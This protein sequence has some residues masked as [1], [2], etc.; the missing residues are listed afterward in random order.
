MIN[1]NPQRAEQ[2][3]ISSTINLYASIEGFV[4]K[5]NVSNGTYVSPSDVILEIVDT[6]HIH[7]ELSVFEKDIMK[8][9]KDQKILFKIP[10]ASETVYEAD[11][12]LVGTTI[13][14]QSRRVKVHGHLDN[15]EEN[16]IVGMFVVADIIIDT[17]TSMGLPIEAL[18]EGDDKAYV[19]VLDEKR[20]NEYYLKSI[21]LNLGKQT[22]SNIEILNHDILKDKQ[23]IIKGTSMLIN[24]SEGGHSH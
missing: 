7:L 22:E 8:I 6:D 12:H 3:Q 21:K 24:N 9:K 16:F 5:V 10:E 23:V 11:V 19:L 14:E 18:I 1:I 13:D 15:E 2:G 17:S 4:S 20:G